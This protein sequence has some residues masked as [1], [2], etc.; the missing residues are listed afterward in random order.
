MAF[1]LYFVSQ[2]FDMTE[3]LVVRGRSAE[4]PRNEPLEHPRALGG[5]VD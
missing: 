5:H 2:Q 4:G 1:T 3:V